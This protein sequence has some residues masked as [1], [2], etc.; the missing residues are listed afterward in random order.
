M[1]TKKKAD[2]VAANKAPPKKRSPVKTKDQ[3]KAKPGPKS[4]LQEIMEKHEL[5]V[6]LAAED[7]SGVQIAEKLGISKSAWYK[8][9]SK[10]KAIMELLKKGRRIATK[11]IENELFQS[12]RGKYV[13]ETEIIVQDGKTRFKKT[14]RWVPG[15]VTAQI[16]ILKKLNPD[17][18]G[19][20]EKDK[21]LDPQGIQRGADGGLPDKVPDELVVRVVYGKD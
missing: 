20:K 2:T 14:R 12:G 10:S 9:C 18:Y 17:E 13:E 8:Y 3:P 15:N 21:G 16:F 5:I 6:E 11:T 19:D 4:K 7:L 1:T